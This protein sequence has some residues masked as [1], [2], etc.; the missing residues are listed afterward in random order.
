MSFAIMLILFLILSIFAVVM[1][2]YSI[3]FLVNIPKDLAR[4]ANSI[5]IM[6]ENM[7]LKGY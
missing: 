6:T 4:I 2:V 5:E 1:F 3:I 7:E